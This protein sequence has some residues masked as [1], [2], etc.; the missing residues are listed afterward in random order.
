LVKKPFNTLSK[1]ALAAVLASTAII[2]V[3]S[4]S[5]DTPYAVEEVIVEQDGQAISI[6]KALYQAALTEG[7][8]SSS[9]I[10][11]IRSTDGK[12]YSKAWYQAAIAEEGSAEAALAFLSTSDK[13]SDITPVVGEFI[14]GEIVPT[15]PLATALKVESVSAINATS[16]EVTFAAATADILGAKVVVKNGAKE[17][18]ATKTTDISEGDTTATF[19]FVT[20]VDEDA[21][22]GVWEVNGVD[23]NFD[24]LAQFEAIVEAANEVALL[25]ALLDAG[26]E[27]VNEDLITAYKT[28]I[29]NDDTAANLADIQA[30]VK[31]VNAA[32]VTAADATAAVKATVDATNQVN[33]L[34]ALQANFVRVNA[35]WITGYS[36]LVDL[37]PAN[38]VA[39]LG[40]SD[41]VDQ[42]EAIQTVIDD[43]N[44][45]EISA[46]VSAAEMSVD[47]AKVSK[48]RALLAAFAVPAEDEDELTVYDYG[49]AVLD[50]ENAVIAV[51][52]ATTNSSLDKALVSLDAKLKELQETFAAFSAAGIDNKF[53][54]SNPTAENFDL[55]LVNSTLLAQYRAALK[56]T[57]TYAAGDRNQAKD[58]QSIIEDVN[59]DSAVTLIG[60]VN[61]AENATALLK[62]L[63]AYPG[64]KQVADINKDFYWAETPAADP[65]PATI[66]DNFEG[67]DADTIQEAVD[68]ANVK[69]TNEATASKVVAQLNVFGIDNV[70]AANAVAYE[71]AF[72]STP[73]E[74]K[75]T[76][77]LTVTAVKAAVKAVN[78]KA[79]EDAAVKA[80]NDAT[81]ATEVKTALDTLAISAYLNVT[82][83]DRIFIAEKVLEARADEADKKYATKSE[84]TVAVGTA[85]TD[86]TTAIN[87]VNLLDIDS[88]LTVIAEALLLVGHTSL[89]GKTGA[90]TANDTSIADAFITSVTDEDGAIVPA[91]RSISD[92][93]TVLAGL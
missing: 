34:K 35:E 36:E 87:T 41:A 24:V 57:E 43:A 50:F 17:V 92:I 13:N 6:P 85:T 19:D 28:A 22:T 70:V 4:V 51:F 53:N 48:A 16:V 78:D 33:L 60:A 68:A 46:A 79:A 47:S 30:I 64:L 7:F 90:P 72:N 2:P 21:L 75:T 14:G 59:G 52:S 91:F 37:T 1:A 27:N 10:E 39:E 44:L 76:N 63:K 15:P 88:S 55:E 66:N 20:A 5:A 23:Y 81:T 45:V 9:D 86:R 42:F 61:E 82:A 93:R 29:D 77:A 32:N 71:A 40:S 62:A 74:E 25:A 84:V 18:V 3:A 83:A 69:A 54:V 58:V 8:V 80:I 31:K 56:D 65:A 49:T 12:Y 11:Y 89:T 26:I 73:L 67:V 38:V